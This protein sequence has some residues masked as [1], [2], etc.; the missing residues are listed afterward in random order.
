MN[1][2]ALDRAGANDGDLD[3]DILEADGFQARQH[4]RLGAALDLKAADGIGLCQQPVDGRIIQGQPVHTLLDPGLLHQG[5]GFADHAQRAQAEQV[6]LDQPGILDGILVPLD[7]H[8]A[9]LG[10]MFQRHDLDQR[11]GGDEHAADM[12]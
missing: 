5:G 1:H 6:D 4:L 3:D 8:H 12:D 7:H 9:G 2:A 11:L 10:G